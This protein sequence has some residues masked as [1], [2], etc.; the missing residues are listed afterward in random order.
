[1]NRTGTSRN[2]N[3]ELIEEN[4]M[5]PVLE[6][7]VYI[8]TRGRMPSYVKP[9]NVSWYSR[10]NGNDFWI[11]MPPEGME[12]QQARVYGVN[13]IV[14]GTDEDPIRRKMKTIAE[15]NMRLVY[16]LR[17]QYETNFIENFPTP[18]E[19]DERRQPSPPPSILTVPVNEEGNNHRGN[20]VTVVHGPNNENVPILTTRLYTDQ[21]GS[22]RRQ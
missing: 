21:R 2:R 18:A 20:I 8:D 14:I 16:Q 3:V 12:L 6:T 11:W 13:N 19:V 17:V 10:I 5:P 15:Q 9:N 1:M 22:V 4:I 7:R